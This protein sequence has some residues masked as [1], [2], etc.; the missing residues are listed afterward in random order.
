MNHRAKVT[1]LIGLIVLLTLRRVDAQ[2][3]PPAT[4]NASS[5]QIAFIATRRDD[6]YPLL[7][8]IDSDGTSE[9][10]LDIDQYQWP[11][12]SLA[13]SPTRKLLAVTT[14]QG[15]DPRIF[16]IN[17]TNNDT[18]YYIPPRSGKAVWSPDGQRLAYQ[19]FGGG[20]AEGF[21]V[22]PVPTHQFDSQSTDVKCDWY[23]GNSQDIR[24]QNKFGNG[25]LYVLSW[26]PDGQYIIF[27]GLKDIETETSAKLSRSRIGQEWLTGGLKAIR[28]KYHPQPVAKR[29]LDDHTERTAKSRRCP[30]NC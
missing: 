27:E 28:F 20:P 23:F 30:A 26:S 9:R 12:L 22:T 18:S 10:I 3:T 25:Q 2:V 13:W 7:H 19:V 4:Q 17:P 11:V 5:N 8:V 15:V 24:T 21:C 1:V 16:I 14:G 6:Y 29:P